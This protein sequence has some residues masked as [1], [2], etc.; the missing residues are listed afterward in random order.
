MRLARYDSISPPSPGLATVA[1]NFAGL[2][3][4]ILEEV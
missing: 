4:T 1:A 3:K 2:A